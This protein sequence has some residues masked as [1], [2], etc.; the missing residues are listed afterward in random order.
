[1]KSTRWVLGVMVAVVVMAKAAAGAEQVKE[2]PYYLVKTLGMDRT[3][4]SVVMSETEL[5]ELEKTLKLEQ[6][7]FAKAVI[8]AGKEWGT[9][10]L[11]KGTMFPGSMLKPRSIVSSMKYP[12]LEKAM[13]KLNKLAGTDPKAGGKTIRGSARRTTPRKTDKPVSKREE[14]LERAADAVKSKLETLIAEAPAPG[15][16]AAAPAAIE[17]GGA[18][19]EVKAH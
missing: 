5:R 15:A 18:R 17:A 1:M 8:L 11:N 4:D 12:S 14:I 2:E 16:P 19:N 9:E 3:P 10:E 6:K 7:Y 13:E